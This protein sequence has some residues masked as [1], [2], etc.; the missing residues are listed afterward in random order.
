[1]YGKSV[2]RIIFGEFKR[3]KITEAEGNLIL[4]NIIIYTLHQKLLTA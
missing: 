4:R 1:V 2:L 3:V